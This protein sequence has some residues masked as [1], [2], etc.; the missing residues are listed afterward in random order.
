LDATHD[1]LEADTLAEL[2]RQPNIFRRTIE[3]SLAVGKDIRE[4]RAT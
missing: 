4:Q 1:Q 3:S 2:R